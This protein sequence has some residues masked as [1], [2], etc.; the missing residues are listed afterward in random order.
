MPGI[1]RPQ[2][3][4]RSIIEPQAPALW[5][6]LWDFE[7][8]APSDPLDPFMV[9]HPPCMAQQC[10][11]PAIAVATILL[12]QRDDI[13]RERLFAIRPARYL[14][15][16]RSMLAQHPA[17]PSLGHRKL[18]SQ[19]VNTASPPRRVQKFPRAASCK[20]SLSNVRSEIARRRRRFSFSRSFIRRV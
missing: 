2:A 11:H 8:L 15:L 13:L 10:R 9:H 4:A 12:C 7:A 5:L 17:D 19:M 16:R 20:I 3:E 18:P 6:A 14:A 1:L